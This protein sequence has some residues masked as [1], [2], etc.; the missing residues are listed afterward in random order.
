MKRQVLG[1]TVVVVASISIFG[2]VSVAGATAPPRTQLRSFS[3][4]HALDPANRS[5]SVTAVMRPVSGT[6][7]MALRFDLLGSTP[8]SVARPVKAGDL[9]VWIAPSNPTLGQL[10]GDVWNLQKSV[11]ALAAP[12]RYRFKVEFRWTGSQGQVL[13]TAVRYSPRCKQAELRPDLAVTSIAVSPIAGQPDYE[14]YTAQVANNGN[15]A[16]GPFDV[17]FA[18]AD[19]ATVKTHTIR[20]LRAHAAMTESFVGP[21]CTR[22][23]DPTITADSTSEVD[24]LNRANNSLQATCPAAVSGGSTRSSASRAPLH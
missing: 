8:T 24:D 9:G 4:Q 11:V 18:S 12:A 14:L 7:H 21:V 19:G 13:G 5:V 3:C 6:Q 17:M 2:S 20:L 10:P 23:S 16:A 1:V 22:A 15:S